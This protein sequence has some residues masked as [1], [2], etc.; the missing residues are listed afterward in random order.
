MKQWMKWKMIIGIHS[1][2]LLLFSFLIVSIM[3]QDLFVLHFIL[4]VPSILLQIPHILVKIFILHFP[5]SLFPFQFQSNHDHLSI[6]SEWDLFGCLSRIHPEL[7][8]EWS[9]DQFDLG[10]SHFI[11]SKLFVFI[12]VFKYWN[13][14]L[15]SFTYC[16]WYPSS[17]SI[18]F[19]FFQFFSIF[20]IFFNF[21]QFRFH[22]IIR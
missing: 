13:S 15:S 18:F 2:L 19:N 4:L 20:S 9:F 1:G 10:K 12:F 6:D 22:F 21:F 17:I 14:L 8:Y 7:Q 5:L 11:S 16:F 3:L